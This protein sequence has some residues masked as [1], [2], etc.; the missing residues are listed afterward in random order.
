MSDSV[1]RVFRNE[2]AGCIPLQPEHLGLADDIL[3]L[4]REGAADAR[5]VP[6]G[7]QGNDVHWQ[8]TWRAWTG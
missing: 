3:G 4:L 8:G 7:D 1:G 6:G 5:I 2:V